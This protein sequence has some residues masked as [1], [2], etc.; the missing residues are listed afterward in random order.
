MKSK[1]WRE[2]R[3]AWWAAYDKKYRT[4]RCYIC[5]ITQAEYGKIFD[6]H[7]RTYERLGNERFDDLVP[8]CRQPCHSI[9]TKRWRARHRTGLT[10]S[11]WELTDLVRAEHR[12][13]AA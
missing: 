1:A 13:K 8:L 5:H 2:R 9:V 10:L 7:H 6:L 4:R 12:A 3:S 11:L